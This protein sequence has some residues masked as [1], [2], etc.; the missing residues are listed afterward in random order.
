MSN[1]ERRKNYR[2][3]YYSIIAILL[4]GIP[5]QAFPYFW[6]LAS[7]VKGSDEIFAVPPTLIPTEWHWETYSQVF[8]RV[9][10]ENY[11]LNSFILCFGTVVIQVTVSCLAAYSL[12]KLKPA[13][14]RLVLFFFLASLMVPGE[15]TLIPTYVMM[16]KFPVTGTNFINKFWSLWLPFSAW[17]Y[18]LFVL[19]TSFDA[20]PDDYIE[21]ARLDGASDLTIFT[22]I[23][24]PLSRPVIS[25]IAVLTFTAVYNQFILPLVMLPDPSRW[26]AM[27]GLYSLQFGRSVP[28]NVVM[29]ATVMVTIPPIV[30]Y[31]IFQRYIQQ[32]YTLSGVKG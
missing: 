21:A 13:Y 24:L 14:A 6:M 19:K 22:R 25:V 18:A 23:I 31:L 20:I 7:S 5:I 15:A 2:W 10:F 9:P 27:V 30:I 16:V 32:G 12:S 8:D 26:P 1:V 29:A 28:W 4:I 3:L 11:M 17:A